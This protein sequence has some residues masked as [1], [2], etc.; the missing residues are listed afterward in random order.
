[1]MGVIGAATG[2]MIG[3]G[4]DLDLDVLLDGKEELLLFLLL[5]KCL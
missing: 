3:I 2:G 1:M 5:P 4:M